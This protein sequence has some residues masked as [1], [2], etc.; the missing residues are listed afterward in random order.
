MHLL[1][2]QAKYMHDIRGGLIIKIVEDIFIKKKQGSFFLKTFNR[3]FN[4]FLN[5]F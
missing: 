2:L 3:F 1:R 4:T 5:N